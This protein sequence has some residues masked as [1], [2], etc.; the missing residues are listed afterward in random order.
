MLM[1]LGGGEVLIVDIR[2]WGGGGAG[3][4]QK[5]KGSPDFRFPKVR[6]SD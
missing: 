3:R 5:K 2:R 1:G 6:I 4:M